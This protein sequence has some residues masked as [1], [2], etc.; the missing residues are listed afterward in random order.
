MLEQLIFQPLKLSS[1]F[2]IDESFN[3]LP[4]K[5]KKINLPTPGIILIPQKDPR[6]LFLLPEIVNCVQTT[7]SFQ[8]SF[9]KTLHNFHHYLDDC[10]F[11]PLELF[12]TLKNSLNVLKIYELFH[13]FRRANEQLLPS[14]KISL[15]QGH[16]FLLYE[17]ECSPEKLEDIVFSLVSSSQEERFV[18]ANLSYDYITASKS[19]IYISFSDPFII[20]ALIQ[21]L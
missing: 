9:T 19:K 15:Q 5:R 12:S 1:D 21:Q 17:G 6:D 3:Y 7:M 20:R 18:F 8:T 4:G 2:L 10:G 14:I 11:F 16:H 13:D